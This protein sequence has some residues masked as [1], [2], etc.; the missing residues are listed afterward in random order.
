MKIDLH[1]HS[2]YSKRPTLWLMQKL[3]CPESFTEPAALYQICRERGMDTVTITDHNVID[4]AIEIADLPGTITGCEYTAY[5]PQDGCKVHVLAYGMTEK[6]HEEITEARENIFDLVDY[7]REHRIQNIC[8]HPLFWVNDRLNIDHIEQLILLFKNWELNGDMAP[9]MNMAVEELVNGLTPEYIDRLSNKH[10]FEPHFRDPWKK[11]LT[12]GSDDHCSLNLAKSFTEIPGAD[13]FDEFWAGLAHG[14]ARARCTESTPQT[15]ARSV[16]SITYQFYKDKM[17]LEKFVQKDLLLRFLDQTFQRRPDS[18]SAAPS[19]ISMF[20]SKRRKVKQVSAGDASLI[21]LARYE[22]EKLIREDPQLEAIVRDGKRHARDLDRKTFEFINQVSN[23]VLL[24][25]GEHLIDRVSNAKIF[26]VFHSLGSAGALYLLLSPYFASFSLHMRERTWAGEVLDATLGPDRPNAKRGRPKV[27]HFT[28]TY[29]EVN[30]VA[31]TI[32]QQVAT[33]QALDKDYTVLTCFQNGRPF[34][35]GVTGF[36]PIGELSLPEYPEVSLLT[37][38]FLQMLSDCYD[39][40]YTH[41]HAAT[42]GPVGLAALGIARILQLPVSGTY[43]TAIPQYAKALTDDG[44]MEEAMWRYMIWFYDQ[45]DT[46]YVPSQATGQELIEHGL[47]EAKVRVYPRG[48]DTERFHPS[49]ASDIL[50]DRWG[51]GQDEVTLLYVGRVSKEKNLHILAAAYRMLI[52]RN[53]KARLIVVGDGP[54]RGAME[55]KL[56]GTPAVFTGYVEGEELTSVYASCSAFIFPS[57]T[58]TF[59]NVVLEAQAAG[60]PVVVT[61]EGGPAENL[62][63]EETGFV[64]AGNSVDALADGME[65][66]A[67]DHMFRDEMGIAARQYMEARGFARAFDQL[68][69]MYTESAHDSAA[70]PA[71]PTDFGKMSDAVRAMAL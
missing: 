58:D 15:F 37:P 35:R 47:S 31:R 68:F 34:E 27:A 51:I 3:G 39:E 12:S 44:F 41:L 21:S 6:Q 14:H 38:P 28:D 8:A 60:T 56:A 17:G 30:G 40:R 13:T 43:H 50:Q 1:C 52:E 10:G 59:G 55:K 11:N 62:I 61:N 57:T 25:F 32:R 4:G 42:P 7:F 53:V 29:D 65:R 49:K 33:A 36:Q 18:D 45:M 66:I 9:E 54:Y 63:A 5:F 64:V 46:V 16:Y 22:A 23:R 69:G 19:R 71:A 70:T 26:D 67:T 48:I 2:K 20:F 24:Q